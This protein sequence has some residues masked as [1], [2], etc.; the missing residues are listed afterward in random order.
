[1]AGRSPIKAAPALY[2]SF[3]PDIIDI[4]KECGYA[5]GL[6]GSMAHDLDLIAVPWHHNA[7]AGS[8]LVRRIADHIGGFIDVKGS[9][10][11]APSPEQKV[12]G[13]VGWC[14]YFNRRF[15][16]PYIDISVTP[17]IDYKTKTVIEDDAA[18]A[19]IKEDLKG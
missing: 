9:T 16:G 10:V 8:E 2:A 6:H 18:A 17:R 5:I 15:I 19:M 12:H 14:I 11:K 3:L 7:F 1:M 4:A 13:R